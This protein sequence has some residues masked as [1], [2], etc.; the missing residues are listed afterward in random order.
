MNDH[1]RYGSLRDY[2]WVLRTQKWLILLVVILGAGVG[3]G[4]ALRQDKK[5]EAL[6]SMTFQDVSQDVGLLGTPIA[7]RDSP[8]V[9]AAQ[10]AA[11]VERSDVLQR[12]RKSLNT[13]LSADDLRDMLSAAADPGSN[14]VVLTVKAGDPQV[15]ADV[16]NAFAHETQGVFNEAARA[17]F[18]RAAKALR[19]RIK[20]LGKR[21][22]ATEKLIFKSQLS[23]LESLSAFANAADI[24]EFARPD[25]DP[26]SPKPVRNAFFGLIIGLGLGLLFA[27]LRDALD[28]RLRTAADVRRELG[29]PII[30]YVSASVF[31]RKLFDPKTDTRSLGDVDL[32]AFRIM[33]RNLEFLDVD[34]PVKLV[35]VTSPLPQEGKTTVAASLAVAAAAS[36]RR[37]LLLEAD[38]RHPTLPGRLGGKPEPGLS[39]YLVGDAEPSDVL[40]LL[41]FTDPHRNENGHGASGPKI[42]YV[43]AGS[44][45]PDPA[46][47]LGSQRFEQLINDVRDAYD[48]IILDT[49][50]VLPVVDTLEFIPKLDAVILCI[51][52]GQTTR[53]QTA[54][55]RAALERFPDR[56]VGV[57]VTGTLASDE[58]SY[59]SY[60]TTYAY[61]PRV[62]AGA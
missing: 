6:A 32:E 15:A 33:R 40:Q 28:R 7:P 49:A 31:G 58:T 1:A 53:A 30:G 60:G 62:G 12:V 43:S 41:E 61:K 18:T 45:T 17:R 38:L 22:D 14:L 19:K 8:G 42:A 57:V 44:A 46:E 2:F 52:V 47:L 54:G 27:F 36:G 51:R 55:A 25:S 34:H 37:V 59:G 9:L 5:Y 50:P 23:R 24:A 16:A 56:P 39:D 48:L 10:S 3:L 35:G 21:V 4:L 29:M 20:S 11:T 26:V 13:S